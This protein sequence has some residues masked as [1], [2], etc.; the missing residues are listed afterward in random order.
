MEAILTRGKSP[1]RAIEELMM[2]PGR[3][4]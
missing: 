4:E 1:E 3:D 2:R